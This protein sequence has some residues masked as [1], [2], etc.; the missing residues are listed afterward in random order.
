MNHANEISRLRLV[1]ER[2]E[3]RITSALAERLIS[4]LEQP[5]RIVIL[6]GGDGVFCE[7]LEL[8]L[9]SQGATGFGNG[10]RHLLETI[11]KTPCPVIALVDGPA[12]GGGCALAAVA[13]LVLAT[14]R[15]TF[16]SPEV[17][18]GLIP[19]VAFPYI[20]RRMTVSRARLLA[21]GIPAIDAAEA[22]RLG[23]V[24]EIV[25]DLEA[26]LAFHSR[27]LLRADPRALADMKA[28]TRVSRDE[29]YETAADRAFDRLLA[30]DATQRRIAKLLDGDV[31]WGEDA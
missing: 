27:R 30:S 15:A 4:A 20:A 9:A 10:F 22:H 21:L 18:W 13:D 17:L 19:A 28:L 26:G 25:P 3:P 6:E 7:G 16:G 11:D 29:R 12:I 1:N 14:P 2:E 24:D 5:A 8:S 23:L 31:P